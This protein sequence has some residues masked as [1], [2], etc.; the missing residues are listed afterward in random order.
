MT[1]RGAHT[2]GGV[3]T[4]QRNRPPLRHSNGETIT[5][6]EARRMGFSSLVVYES[7]L[8]L[9]AT[10]VEAALQTMHQRLPLGYKRLWRHAG[11]GA[12]GYKD[13]TLGHHKVFIAFSYLVPNITTETNNSPLAIV[14]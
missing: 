13:T 4:G 14:Y 2:P 8:Q 10:L 11:K 1:E 6:G 12:K 5:M 3:Y 7:D 9:N